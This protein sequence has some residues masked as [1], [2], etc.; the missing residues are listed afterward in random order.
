MVSGMTLDSSEVG[1]ALLYLAA[2]QSIAYGTRQIVEHLAA[3]GLKVMFAAP[4]NI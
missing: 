4:L 1:V 3:H 2:L